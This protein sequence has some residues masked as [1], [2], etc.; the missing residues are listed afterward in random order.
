MVRSTLGHSQ[1]CTCVVEWILRSAWLSLSRRRC[2]V[3]TRS[4]PWDAPELL[5]LNRERLMSDACEQMHIFEGQY[6]LSSDD[7]EA[8]LT[9]GKIKETSDVGRWLF[10]LHTYRSLSRA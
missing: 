10:A 4:S 5:A 8:A 3:V 2:A 1:K 9:A 6:Q 7:L